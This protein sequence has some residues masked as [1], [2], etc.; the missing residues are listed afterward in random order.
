MIGFIFASFVLTFFT[1]T[2]LWSQSTFR[3]LGDLP[4]GNFY[5]EAWGVSA[6]GSIVIGLSESSSG[7]EAF[8]CTAAGIAAGDGLGDLP[9]GDFYSRAR[10]VSGDG[11][12]VIGES[13]S[14]ASEPWEAFRWT[15]LTG[16][17]G[18]G[19]LLDGWFDS[20]ALAI[21]ADGSVI[22]GQGTVVN[23]K[24]E[25]FR[26][27]G[28]VIQPSDGLGELPGGAIYSSG[29]GVSQDGSVVVGRS[30]STAGFEAFRWTE[31]GGMQPLGVLPGAIAH[32][33]KA[34]GVSADGSVVV[35]GS[36]GPTDPS[37]EAFRWENG[38]MAGLGD[39]PGGRHWSTAKAV[40]ADGAIV[41]GHGENDTASLAFIWDADNGI[42]NLK[43]VLEN[44]YGLDLTGWILKDA[45]AIS[46][47]GTTIVGYG[48]NADG[49]REGWIAVLDPYSPSLIVYLKDD[50]GS[51]LADESITV[52][53]AY[54]GSWG[55]QY[56]GTTD[57]NGAF[58]IE[59]MEEGYTKIRMTFNQASI[60]QTVAELDASS[61]TWTAVPLTIQFLDD[62]YIGLADGKVDQGGSTWVHHGYT[63][64]FG[65]LTLHV[66][67][68][69][70]YKF[71][72]GYP[73]TSMTKTFNVPGPG[74]HTEIFQTVLA[75]VTVLDYEDYGLADVK[76]DQGGGS[77]VH[78]GYTDINGE[79]DLQLSGGTNYKF[80]VSG[81]A[82]S[83][84][85]KTTWFPVPGPIEFQTGY[86]VSGGAAVKASIG[87][88]W[89]TY[90]SPGMHIL[91]G[92]Y[93]FV[94]ASP[95]PSP[96]Y[97]TVTAGELTNIP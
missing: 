54:G 69:K 21:S 84:S 51:G 75:T 63:D 80:K 17:Q 53:P 18:M 42:R 30:A 44:D 79:L 26:T 73:Y 94:F 27:T 55:P 97:M 35:G 66:F 71:R 5:S 24:Y 85:S 62:I 92:T 12:I 77:W 83:N 86:V 19:D 60:E 28:S 2:S 57:T 56:S 68:E 96:Q 1:P 38:V 20:V 47:D 25:C 93:K 7:T 59:E 89:V 40:S 11:S 4:G 15:S 61:Y 67:P 39:L 36:Q 65:Q 78:H 81:A 13:K 37:Y 64:T 50:A 22:V 74:A 33:S 32:S 91:P 49:N 58:A 95:T 88:R 45:T 3:G 9:G 29:L 72:V 70:Q 23:Y 8:Q 14:G 52:Q 90:S 34:F 82:V 76:V 16:M 31:S 41:V 46:A 10:G 87:G 43:S 6:D 48:T